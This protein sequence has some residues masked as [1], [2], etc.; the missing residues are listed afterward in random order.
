MRKSTIKRNSM[1]KN[2]TIKKKF[3]IISQAILMISGRTYNP[4]DPKKPIFDIRSKLKLSKPV[5][6]VYVGGLR[7][8]ASEDQVRDL[9]S[10][11][12]R[13][14]SVIIPISKTGN[15][16]GCA[17]VAFATESDQKTAIQALNETEF[18]GRKIFV[19]ERRDPDPNAPRIDKSMAG[20]PPIYPA[21]DF[22]DD[23]M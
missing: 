19:D 20:Q 16:K 13:V 18:M 5:Y 2:V 6:Q 4:D 7:Y 22:E 15:A 1:F 9:F 8:S 3:H 11:Y 23:D 21:N 14:V 17:F 12:G 10:K